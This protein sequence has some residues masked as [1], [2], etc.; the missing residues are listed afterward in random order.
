MP[1]VGCQNTMGRDV[2]IPWVV[3]RYTM[4]RKLDIPLIGVSKC[5]G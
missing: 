2:N 5:H 1:W 4:G 3:G